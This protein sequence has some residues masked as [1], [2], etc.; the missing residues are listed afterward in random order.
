MKLVILPL[1]L[2]AD[3]ICARPYGFWNSNGYNGYALDERST[4]E[5]SNNFGNNLYKQRVQNSMLSNVNNVPILNDNRIFGNWD[6]GVNQAPAQ[7][8]S[9]GWGNLGNTVPMVQPVN[10][11]VFKPVPQKP[12]QPVNN[13]FGG[14]NTYSAFIKRART[15]SRKGN[16]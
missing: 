10:K 6:Q 8:F 15:A 1:F 9:N 5:N 13:M 11:N 4:N 3:L 7:P 14:W 12:I 2:S 16:F